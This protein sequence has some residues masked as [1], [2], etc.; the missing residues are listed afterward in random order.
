[1]PSKKGGVLVQMGS[2]ISSKCGYLTPYLRK[3]VVYI[4]VALVLVLST[5]LSALN[6]LKVE[7]GVR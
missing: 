7:K 3:V 4:L 1:M 5:L 2:N 6:A